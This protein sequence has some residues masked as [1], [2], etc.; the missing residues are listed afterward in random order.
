MTRIAVTG[1]S[2]RMGRSLMEVVLKDKETL[3][4]AA[5]VKPGS[6]LCGADAGEL[7]SMGQVGVILS[8]DLRAQLNSFD[9]L[10]DFTSPQSTL[11]NLEICA[12]AGKSMVIGTTGFSEKQ[13]QVLDT[14]S[15]EL[16]V[17]FAANYSMGVNLALKVLET[18]A[19]TLGDDA[20]IEILE[21][22]HRHKVD[23]PS[24]TALAMGRA[25][26]DALGRNLDDCAVY[27]RKGITGVRKPESIGFS[28]ARAGDVVGDHTVLF[29]SE[30]ERLEI[31]HKAS[32]R[33]AFSRGAVR[34]AKWINS[35]PAS[36]LY[37]MIDVLGL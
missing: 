29:A 13:L 36:K 8:D 34:A 16:P 24:G 28:T 25:V 5:L 11:E 6:S 17:C 10:I 26:A 21:T 15:A 23:A 30:G 2:G 3:L 9:V 20:D 12:S 22:H 33:M 32:N 19:K 4:T 1:A 35:Q 14:K 18:V 27:D 7:V 31:T 37:S